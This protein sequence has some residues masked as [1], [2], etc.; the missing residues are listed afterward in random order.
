MTWTDGHPQ[1]WARTAAWGVLACALPSALW[2]LLMIA[3]LSV[4]QLAA[5]VL[6]VGLVRPWGE[7]F[8]GVPI[9]RW[10]PSPSGRSAG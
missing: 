9:P 8:L 4:A 5:A 7:R 10:V 6:V 2:R 3:G 1:R